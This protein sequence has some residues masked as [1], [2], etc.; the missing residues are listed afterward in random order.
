MPVTYDACSL[1]KCTVS[2][3]YIRYILKKP[4]SPTTQQPSIGGIVG[5][6]VGDMARFNSRSQASNAGQLPAKTDDW[7]KA[8]QNRSLPLG[9]NDLLKIGSG[10]A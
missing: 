5:N 8:V 7:M 3:S 2:M 4:S 6:L 9:A 1:L 10:I